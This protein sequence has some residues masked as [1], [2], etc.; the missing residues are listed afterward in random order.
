M[1][2]EL[3]HGPGLYHNLVKAANNENPRAWLVETLKHTTYACII[4]HSMIVEDEEHT[5]GGGFNCSYDNMN[6]DISTTEISSLTTSSRFSGVWERFGH[7]Y[8]KI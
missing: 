5:C 8:N 1:K 3:Y 4:L 6:N 7:E 2:T